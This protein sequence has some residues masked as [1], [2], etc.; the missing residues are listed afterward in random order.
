MGGEEDIKTTWREKN[1]RKKM[2]EDLWEWGLFR[3]KQQLLR[4][5]WYIRGHI[6]IIKKIICLVSREGEV[7]Y[8]FNLIFWGYI[9][10][11]S[12]D[13]II[14]TTYNGTVNHWPWWKSQRNLVYHDLWA[15]TLYFTTVNIIPCISRDVRKYRRLW[16]LWYMNMLTIK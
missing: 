6:I 16:A 11:R 4:S 13:R 7:L 1:A 15:Y 9:G 3:N 5:I 10:I 12:I 2:Q 8:A 14:K